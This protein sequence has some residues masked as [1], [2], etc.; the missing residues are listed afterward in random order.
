M[1]IKS[2]PVAHFRRARAD[3]HDKFVHQVRLNGAGNSLTSL[4][5]IPLREICVGSQS[6]TCELGLDTKVTRDHLT[7]GCL[8]RPTMTARLALAIH[9]TQL[10]LKT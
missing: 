6:I 1:G 7:L 5:Q 8:M 10:W 2:L 4:P 3:P 9:T